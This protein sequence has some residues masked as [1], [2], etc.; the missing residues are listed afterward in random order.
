MESKKSHLPEFI[1][2]SEIYPISSLPFHDSRYSSLKSD[3]LSKYGVLPSYIARAPGRVN[4]IGEHIDY[5]G[6]GVLPFALEQDTLIAFLSNDSDSL[7]I[8]HVDP[9]KYPS[10]TLSNNPLEIPKD[11]KAYYNYLLAGYR[12]VMI[13]MMS[14]I[15]SP[16][17]IKILIT[18]NVPIASGLSSSAAMVVC[19]AVM[20]VFA[21]D[22]NNK[23]NLNSF[24]ENTIEY[25]RK[26]GTA[27]G[28][29]D[30]TI[31]IMG[32]TNKALYIQFNPI[33]TEDV[34]LPKNICFIIANSL[35]ESKKMMTLGT[36]YNKRVCEC[37]LALILIMKKLGIN[38][39]I[40]NLS[41]LQNELGFNF[42]KMKQIVENNLK[43]GGYN[44]EEIENLLQNTLVNTL[45]D[46]NHYD[47]VL[48]Q[49]KEFFLQVY[50]L[51]FKNFFNYFK[52]KSSSRLFRS[53]KSIT[54]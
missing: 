54:I 42:E 43:K 16:K 41:E 49:N 34:P 18:G 37:R 5:M 53:R 50:N 24:T 39:Q 6:Y 15:K 20:T 3:F 14:L 12:S 47:I 21:N 7:E 27:I 22:L 36:R 52:G 17:G 31:S 13:P 38:K 4:L 10:I 11:T 51:V 28:G 35:T 48:E 2:P 30:Q 26:L 9:S 23:I 45:K 44:K 29:M 19:S 40:N 46:I 33:R 25:E 8:N 32:E 1:S